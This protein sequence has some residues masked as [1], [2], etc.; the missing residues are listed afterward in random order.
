MNDDKIARLESVPQTL[1]GTLWASPAALIKSAPPIAVDQNYGAYY[2]L[3]S[4][5]TSPFLDATASAEN[6]LKTAPELEPYYDALIENLRRWS[7]INYYRA[8][9]GEYFVEQQETLFVDGKIDVGLATELIGN[10]FNYGERLG[11]SVP[12]PVMRWLMQGLADFWNNNDKTLEECLGFVQKRGAITPVF[13]DRGNYQYRRDLALQ[14]WL[15]I[16]N[17]L[18]VEQAAQL[19]IARDEMLTKFL[20]KN[21]LPRNVMGVDTLINRWPKL[22]TDFA[23]DIS[24]EYG[25]NPKYLNR[26]GLGSVCFVACTSAADYFNQHSVIEAPEAD[27]YGEDFQYP[28]GVLKEIKKVKDSKFKFE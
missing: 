27:F 18:N 12:P 6:P 14:M 28:L 21:Q 16:D 24:R 11:P 5:W 3:L 26:R 10:H 17:G 2:R 8:W 4:E 22:K 7:P 20:G 25:S 9:P 13:K 19:V 1:C 23:A 15:L